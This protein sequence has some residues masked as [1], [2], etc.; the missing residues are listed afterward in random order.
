[1]SSI[2][3]EIRRSKRL[4]FATHL[5]VIKNASAQA[6]EAD[7]PLSIPIGQLAHGGGG[8]SCVDRKLQS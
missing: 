2:E 8:G 4:R 1:M 6:Q 7:S 3:I 5:D